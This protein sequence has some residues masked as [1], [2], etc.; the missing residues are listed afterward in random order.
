MGKNEESQDRNLFDESGSLIGPKVLPVFDNR[1]IHDLIDQTHRRYVGY[2]TR[3]RLSEMK[4]DLNERERLTM[5]G[6][7]AAVEILNRLGVLDRSMLQKILPAPFTADHEVLDEGVIGHS[8][9]PQ[10]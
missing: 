8:F 4:R 10:K 1:V 3:I 2:P 6:F 5:A 7:E 9:T